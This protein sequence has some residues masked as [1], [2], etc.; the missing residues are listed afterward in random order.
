MKK[1][2][3]LLVLSGTLALLASPVFADGTSPSG[4]G[5]GAGG[6]PPPQTGTNTTSTSTSTTGVGT[7]ISEIISIAG[8]V[9]L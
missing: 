4:S 5:P 9:G 3:R 7:I 8:V 2:L 6:N 1:A